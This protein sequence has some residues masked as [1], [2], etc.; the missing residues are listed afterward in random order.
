M[1][2]LRAEAHHALHARA[3]VPG[4][5]EEHDLAR[6]REVLDVAL[7][8]PRRRLA[9]RRLLQRH[10]AGSTGIEVL[11]EALDGAALAGGVAALEEDDVLLAGFLGPVLP[12]QQLDLEGA[13]GLLVLLA[14]H[15]LL[16]RV[17]LAPRF[18]RVAGRGD[19]H[20]IVLVGV[21]HDVPLGRRQIDDVE[22]LFVRVS[23]A[24]SLPAQRPRFGA[25]SKG[26]GHLSPVKAL[27]TECPGDGRGTFRGA[28]GVPGCAVRGSRAGP[29]VDGPS[30]A[31]AILDPHRVGR[32]AAIR[33]RKPPISRRSC[34]E[35]TDSMRINVLDDA[36]GERG[37][38]Q[39]KEEGPAPT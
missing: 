28:A 6:R 5:V 38:S 31:A 30:G 15:A 4:A 1:L 36:H 37:P 12:L 24:S 13:L 2:G 9:R 27:F 17:V 22:V 18:D 35:S 23:H 29:G 10:G 33:T 26:P 7:E 19:Q 34:H 20:R 21:V 16:V 25:A 3:V 39:S 11:V 14:R 8:V 32:F